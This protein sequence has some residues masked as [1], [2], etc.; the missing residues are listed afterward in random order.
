MAAA[1]TLRIHKD[2]C[3]R[4]L[5]SASY[6]AS[7]T[8]AGSHIQFSRRAN[9]AV[10]CA[11][12]AKTDVVAITQICLAALRRID[13]LSATP[14][15][16]ARLNTIMTGV[17]AWLA[18]RSPTTADA[19]YQ[20]TYRS[21]ADVLPR[22]SVHVTFDLATDLGVLPAAVE[23]AAT[24]QRDVYWAHIGGAL[25]PMLDGAGVT[26]CLAKLAGS[27]KAATAGRV[28]RTT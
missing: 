28:E 1:E 24:A 9:L 8:P 13:L 25:A 18:H 12:L 17:E 22:A 5:A 27:I 6:L 23:Q 21:F 2:V 14:A 15:E 7:R 3:N 19:V 11:L 16:V 20:M 10:A 26:A 4:I